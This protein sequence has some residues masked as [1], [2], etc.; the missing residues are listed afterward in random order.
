[1]PLVRPASVALH[2]GAPSWTATARGAHLWDAHGRRHL[3]M[4]CLDGAALLGHADPRVEAAAADPPRDCERRASEAL[5]A[6]WHGVRAIGFVASTAA[7]RQAATALAVRATDRLD[8]VAVAAPEDLAAVPERLREA[9]ALV[10]DASA[11]AVVLHQARAVATAA[12]ALLI[13]DE[14]ATGLRR[15]GMRTCADLIVSGLGLANGRPIGAVAGD[16]ELLSHLP[17]VP[18]A[19]KPAMAAAAVTL[20]VVEREDVAL[21]L[22]VRGAEIQAGLEAACGEAGVGDRLRIGGDPTSIRLDF[23]GPDAP[24][25]RRRFLAQLSARAVHA[26]GAWHVSARHEDAEIDA[27]LDAVGAAM[28]VLAASAARAA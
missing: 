10:V 12:G 15:V 26:P 5:A 8:V 1:M 2:R 28:P 21:Q 25:L 18:P 7:A 17:D 23:G 13:L 9:A 16:P 14:G 3:D 24:R 4:A 27:L 22:A 20:A 19:T 6:R 11:P